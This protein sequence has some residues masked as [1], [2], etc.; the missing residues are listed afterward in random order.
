[1]PIARVLP[2]YS[3][4]AGAAAAL[5]VAM[6]DREYRAWYLDQ[7]AASRALLL[8]AC[9]RLG[10]ETSPSVA[11]FVLVRVG[12]NAS[13]VVSALAARGILVRDRSRERGCEQCIRITAGLVTDTERA[14]EALAEVL[15]AAR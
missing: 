3:A 13:D 15:C 8:E 4:N 5:P 11:N 7:S 9:A 12:P 1:M 2:P 14:I 10:L 6:A